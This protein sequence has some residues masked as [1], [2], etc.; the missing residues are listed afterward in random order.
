AVLT[1]SCGSRSA[2]TC[3]SYCYGDAG[4]HWWAGSNVLRQNVR[5]YFL[6][7]AAQYTR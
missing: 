6:W 3:G 4:S 2:T 1:K 7:C 5:Y